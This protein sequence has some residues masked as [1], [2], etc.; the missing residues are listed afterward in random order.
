MPLFLINNQITIG[1]PKIDVIALIGKVKSKPG[2][3]EI[4][5]QSNIIS[6]PNT[7]VDKNN[8]L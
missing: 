4:V 1:A 8:I 7:M 5:S 2:N 3:C 6:A